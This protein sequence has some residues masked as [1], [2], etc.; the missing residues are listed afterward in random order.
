MM[1]S[2]RQAHERLTG[3]RNTYLEGVPTWPTL[4]S[5]VV[6]LRQGCSV[7][8]QSR[9]GAGAVSTIPVGGETEIHSSYSRPHLD[10]RR[11][12]IEPVHSAPSR[13]RRSGSATPTTHAGN[14]AETQA[15]R[16]SSP[17]GTTSHTRVLTLGWF[18]CMAERLS[19]FA[20]T[21]SNLPVTGRM[22]VTVHA[23]KSRYLGRAPSCAT[24]LTPCGT[25]H[26]A[27]GAT[28]SWITSA[29]GGEL[30]RDA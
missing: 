4:P 10:P 26:D 7:P 1:T 21:A 15:H 16:N 18:V 23:R 22:T 8:I 29:G 5:S 9:R 13:M 14:A 11:D 6:L 25:R 19:I 27:R 12:S 24:R 3:C 2:A 20:S 28:S 17:A 30:P